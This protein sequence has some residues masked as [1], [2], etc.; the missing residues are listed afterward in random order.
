MQSYLQ[1]TK[2][3]RWK[4]VIGAG[5]IILLIGTMLPSSVSTSLSQDIPSAEEI[6]SFKWLAEN[7]P[8]N[9]TVLAL[10]EEGH[11]VTYF[12]ERKNIMDTE[13]NQIE[14][15]EKVF[16]DA[17]AL[18][19]TSFHTRALKIME[20][21]DVGYLVITPKAKEKYSIGTFKYR[22]LSCFKRVYK[23]ETKIYELGCILQDIN[24]E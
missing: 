17:S 12:G 13:F 6:E 15:V 4:K 1:Q 2:A 23:N 7:T 24:A 19:T 11:L 9:T 14:Q 5:V 3:A 18:Y 8:K 10:I 21:Y 16:R 22:D 20:R